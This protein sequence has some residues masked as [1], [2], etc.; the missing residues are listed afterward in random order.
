MTCLLSEQAFA[1]GDFNISRALA[2]AELERSPDTPWAM[3]CLDALR[4]TPWGARQRSLR[5]RWRVWRDSRRAGPWARLDLETWLDQ[6]PQSIRLWSGVLRWGETHAA[7]H[8]LRMAGRRLLQLRHR[9]RGWAL[10][11]AHFWLKQGL[12][13]EAAGRACWSVPRSRC[14]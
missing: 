9:D 2:R 14:G 3:G 5:G 4:G 1:Q 13:T 8:T 6:F 10:D 7:P 11:L 12:S